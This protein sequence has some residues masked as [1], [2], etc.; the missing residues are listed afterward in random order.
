MEVDAGDALADLE[1][2]RLRRAGVEDDA[3]EVDAEGEG[4]LGLELVLPAAEQQV[5]EGDTGAVHLDQHVVR[6]GDRLGDLADLDVGGT[7]EGD[8]LGC[9]HGGQPT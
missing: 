7:G 1:A 2:A 6:A 9:A 8:D 3:G 5:G 4:R